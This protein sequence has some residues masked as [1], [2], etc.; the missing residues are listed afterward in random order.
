MLAQ[1]TKM[2]SCNSRTQ[3]FQGFLTITCTQGHKTVLEGIS[4]QHLPMTLWFQGPVLIAFDSICTVRS[5]P[6]EPE[7]RTFYGIPP[8][9][10]GML[11]ITL[12]CFVRNIPGIAVELSGHS[13]ALKSHDV[14][15][16]FVCLPSL[17]HTCHDTTQS[18]CLYWKVLS[19]GFG[20]FHSFSI[21][22][23]PFR[24]HMR[25]AS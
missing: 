22:S 20:G 24:L 7:T 14:L 23:R 19:R 9:V 1:N 5:H 4:R 12:P 8:L 16:C 15:Y 13:S 2:S 3:G 11:E 18:S 10:R 25:T 21:N 6:G 17:H